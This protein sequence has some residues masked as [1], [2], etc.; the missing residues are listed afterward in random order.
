MGRLTAV[1]DAY[2]NVDEYSYFLDAESHEDRLHVFP[3][4][5]TEK[6]HEDNRTL[7]NADRTPSN[8]RPI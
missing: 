5:D 8:E 7:G 6:R 1:V 2:G 3:N 4:T